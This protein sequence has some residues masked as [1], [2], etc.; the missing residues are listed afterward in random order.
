MLFVLTVAIIADRISQVEYPVVKA[1][2][3]VVNVEGYLEFVCPAWRDQL[4]HT[5]CRTWSNV[6][7]EG[8]RPLDVHTDTHGIFLLC[9]FLNYS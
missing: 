8:C 3:I 6:P 4:H 1:S 9:S 5:S 2:H 7:V